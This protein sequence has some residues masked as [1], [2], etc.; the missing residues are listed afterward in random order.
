MDFFAN[1]TDKKKESKMIKGNLLGLVYSKG[2]DIFN[3]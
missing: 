3:K 2:D 1:Q